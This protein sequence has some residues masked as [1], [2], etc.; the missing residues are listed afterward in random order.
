M[1]GKIYVTG[2]LSQGAKL[3]SACVYDPQTDA[4]TRLASMDN[5]RRAHASAVVGGKLY[6][7]GGQGTGGSEL[8]TAEV[9]DPASNSWAQGLSLTSE[10]SSFVAVAL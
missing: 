8:V 7:F 10:R 4:W 2:G 5:A 6:I 9:Y 3:N 1:G